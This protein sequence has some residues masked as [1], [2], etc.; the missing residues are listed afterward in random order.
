MF[1]KGIK[2]TR[3]ERWKGWKSQCTLA[4]SCTSWLCSVREVRGPDIEGKEEREEWQGEGGRCN[5]HWSE[6][7]GRTAER[8]TG[9]DH[10]S[11]RKGALNDEEKKQKCSHLCSYQRKRDFLEFFFEECIHLCI[12]QIN[13]FAL[14]WE[15]ASGTA[16]D[17]ISKSKCLIRLLNGIDELSNDS[18][19]CSWC[20]L[21]ILDHR[22][23]TA[24]QRG[25]SSK[26]VQIGNISMID[27]FTGVEIGKRKNN[28]CNS[29]LKNYVCLIF[30]YL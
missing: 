14:F 16:R 25:N 20:H 9:I 3:E 23:L 12:F 21:Q 22:F 6:G 26:N 7:S 30:C 27:I 15:D 24:S 29:E 4:V 2:T 5:D 28:Y 10:W 19:K 18:S 8:K 13:I 1:G 17:I 11:G